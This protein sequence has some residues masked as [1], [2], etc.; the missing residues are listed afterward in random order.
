MGQIGLT[1]QMREYEVKFEAWFTDAGR[2]VW[3]TGKQRKIINAESRQDAESKIRVGWPTGAGGECHA[4]LI[5][6]R[7]LLRVQNN[8]SLGMPGSTWDENFPADLLDSD[9]YA[10]P[11]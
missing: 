4:E 10:Y 8:V 1:G 2:N 7:L 3:T 5:P 9:A 11:V 6:H